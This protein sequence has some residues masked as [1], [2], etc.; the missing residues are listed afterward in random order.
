MDSIKTGGSEH[1]T[2]P[3]LSEGNIFGEISNYNKHELNC[4]IMDVLDKNISFGNRKFE[5]FIDF[6]ISKESTSEELMSTYLK[7]GE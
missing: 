3:V 5:E 2:D 6:L 4:L 7:K 1:S